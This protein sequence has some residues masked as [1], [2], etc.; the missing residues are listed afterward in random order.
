MKRIKQ[1]YIIP[2]IATGTFILALICLFLPFLP[3][4]WFLLIMTA[5]LLTPYFKPMKKLLTWIIEKD[6]TGVFEKARKKVS[7]LYRWA[8]DEERAEEMDEFCDETENENNK[9]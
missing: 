3:F 9:A 4:G 7:E 1:P 6:K 5:I 2:L 8:G